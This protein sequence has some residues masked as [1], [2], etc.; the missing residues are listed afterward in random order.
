[1]AAVVRFKPGVSDPAKAH[2]KIRAAWSTAASVWGEF[3]GDAGE[4][5]VT[6]LNDGSHRVG[7]YHGKNQAA[8]L[9][10]KNL[11]NEASKRTAVKRLAMRLGATI[12]KPSGVDFWQPDGRGYRVLLEGLGTDN[13]H[14]HVEWRG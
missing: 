3:V 4:L 8:D 11:P 7:S 10:T 6:S 12:A 5:V 9:R 2:P 1:M 14:C 13:E